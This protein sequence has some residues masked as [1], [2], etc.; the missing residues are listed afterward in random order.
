MC[1]SACI[2]TDKQA[3]EDGA[4]TFIC[5]PLDLFVAEFGVDLA[6]CSDGFLMLFVGVGRNENLECHPTVVTYTCV[7]FG[8]SV[9]QKV[10]LKIRSYI[11]S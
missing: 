3:V 6:C 5:H 10:Y 11:A 4:A 9:T 7:G 2:Q 8:I 1:L